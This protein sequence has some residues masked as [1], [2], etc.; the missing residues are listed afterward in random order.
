MNDLTEDEEKELQHLREKHLDL[1]DFKNK[2]ITAWL[3]TQVDE[4]DPHVRFERKLYMLECLANFAVQWLTDGN[5]ITEDSREDSERE[6][7]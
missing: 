2:F 1:H 7:Y 4:S 5:I 3:H 6:Q